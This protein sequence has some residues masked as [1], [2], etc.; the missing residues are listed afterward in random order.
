MTKTEATCPS[1]HG[2]GGFERG[3]WLP[4]STCKGAKMA[5]V[6]LG[7]REELAFDLGKEAMLDVAEEWTRERGAGHGDGS[8]PCSACH[9]LYHLRDVE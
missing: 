1:C 3:M 2:D 8:C 9:L 5:P 4:C 7:F 6:P